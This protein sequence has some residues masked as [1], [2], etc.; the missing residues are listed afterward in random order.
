MKVLLKS[1][2]NVSLFVL[3]RIGSAFSFKDTNYRKVQDILKH[4]TD[5]YYFWTKDTAVWHET[6]KIKLHQLDFYCSYR[7]EHTGKIN[8]SYFGFSNDGYFMPVGHPTDDVNK[9]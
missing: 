6:N 7:N 2:Y 4:N 9:L 8:C 3:Q 1:C 5:Y